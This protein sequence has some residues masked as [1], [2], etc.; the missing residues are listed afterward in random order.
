[1]LRYYPGLR[2]KQG[3]YS[4]LAKLASDIRQHIEPRFVIPSAKEYDPELGHVPSID[5]LAYI[6]G[7]R[8]GKHWPIG[9]A[10]LDA[11]FIERDLDQPSLRK[12]FRL[13]QMRNAEIV[14]VATIESLQSGLYDGVRGDGGIKLALLIGY[15]DVDPST[16]AGVLR[17]AG[18]D[19]SDCVVFVDFTGASLQPEIAAGSVAGIFDTVN[20]IG[21][22]ARIV[23][24]ASNF[25]LKNPAKGGADEMVP[26][27]EWFSFHLAMAEC[28]VP[29]DVIGYGDFA[30]DCGEMSFPKKGGGR[31]IRHLRYTTET[32]TLVVRAEDTGRDRELMQDVCKRI[33]NSGYFAGQAFSA[34]DDAIFCVAKGIG[35]V[36]PG[37]GST[38]REWNTVHHVTRVVRDLGKI[39]GVRFADRKVT[40]EE[41]NERLI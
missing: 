2:F 41:V 29:A 9:R 17:A 15:E 25:P 5:E 3:E 33:L 7:E 23:Y 37:N 19:A 8:I 12:M 39:A 40:A 38:W 1:M 24:Q 36:G 34:A 6:T 30:A 18:L 21:R 10:F 4:G 11:Q 31:A 16:I 26:R 35:G 28:H 22:W 32:A 20:G 14:P 27:H 13:A